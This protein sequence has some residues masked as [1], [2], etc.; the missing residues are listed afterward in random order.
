ML[1]V[2]LS[3]FIQMETQGCLLITTS[4]LSEELVTWNN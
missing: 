1:L 2:L 3:W 4:K